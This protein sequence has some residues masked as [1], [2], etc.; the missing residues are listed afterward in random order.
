MT[1]KLSALTASIGLLMLGLSSSAQSAD[2]IITNAVIYTGQGTRAEAL[3]I[4]NGLIVFI[5]SAQAAEVF[6]EDDTNII[7][8]QQAFVMP[9]FVDNHNHIFEG[10]SEAGGNCEVAAYIPM[11]EQL[12][13]LRICQ[14]NA[15]GQ[16]WLLGYGFT[17]E[18]LLDPNNEHTPLEFLD[19]IFP[20]QPVVL[21]E[22]TSHSMWVNSAAL[23]RVGITATSPHPQ[24]GR[25]LRDEFT[26]ELNGVLLDNAGDIVME[27]AWNSL[28][29]KF[30]Q[31]Y[32]GL[33]NG[34]YEV[35]RNGITTV[36]DGRLYWKRGWLDVWQ[37]AE[38]RGDLTARV[39]LRPWI[40]P[41]DAMAPQ[42]KF[43]NRVHNDDDTSLLRL[44]QVKMYSDGIIINGT[45]KTLAPYDFTYMPDSD[46]GLFYIEPSQMKTWLTSLADID[47]GA[48][49]HAIG[50]GAVK[51]SLDAIE[52]LGGRK[53]EQ[54]YTLTHVEMVAPEDITRFANLGVTADFQVGSDYIAAHDHSWA[55]PFL[56]HSRSKAMMPVAK[57]YNTGANV[58]LSSDWNVHSL[59]PLVGIANS[60]IMGKTGL[61]NIDSA[62]AA[63]TINPAKSL[64]LDHITGEIA[65]GKS[66]D[67]VV[68]DEDITRLS[69]T[70]IKQTAILMTLL[71]GEIVF[72]SEDAFDEEG[73]LDN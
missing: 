36:G 5:G 64:S 19:S 2:T 31:S 25:I 48:H 16:D 70:A 42:L 38:K 28:N 23:A 56:G 26:G 57:L 58:S 44:D 13:Y 54:A 1:Y 53:S 14:E 65:L 12:P 21:M 46:N 10:A 47:Y 27:H 33:M 41:Q 30:N 17:L 6:R 59:N 68:L 71:Q 49:I 3:A 37:A 72:D 52:T 51:A 40:Y 39:S 55:V 9:G 20:V 22:Q 8:M 45:A 29:N 24:G 66:A 43:L 18:T 73:A 32:T 61:P 35:A 63:Y 11:E 4:Q 60:L 67:L 50:D 34:L 69:P 15:K 7:D 62:I